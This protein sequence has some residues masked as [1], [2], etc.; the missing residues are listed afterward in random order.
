MLHLGVNVDHVATVRQARYRGVRGGMTPEPSPLAFALACEAAGAHGITAHV[1]EDRR[2]MQDA[3]VLELR[4]KSG[5]PLNLEMAG[6]PAMV[7]FALRLFGGNAW[8]RRTRHVC[9]VPEKR[10]ELTT[11]GGLDVASAMA[12]LAA[13]NLALQTRGIVVSLFIDPHPDQI[14]AAADT[15]ADVV[16]LHTGAYANAPSARAA[17]AE[18][19]RLSAGAA[20]AHSLGLGVNAGHG[21][22]YDNLAPFLR[23]VPHLHELNIGHAIVSRALLTGAARAVRDMLAL[24]KG[25]RG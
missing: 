12:P 15:G 3:D 10:E 25:Y 4:A 19:R 23:A 9:L 21:L 16:E 5:L 2:H 20:L 13:T 7:K 17:L 24:M 1:R 22:H 14:R 8:K 6:T 18:L 11:E